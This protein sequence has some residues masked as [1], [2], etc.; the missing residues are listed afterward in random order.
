M[1]EKNS[2]VDVKQN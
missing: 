1:Q 2:V